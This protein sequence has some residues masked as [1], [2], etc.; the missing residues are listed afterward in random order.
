MSAIVS[1]GIE[2]R[3]T[4]GKSAEFVYIIRGAENEAAVRDAVLAVAPVVYEGLARRYQQIETI[5]FDSTKTDS[6]IHSS[7]VYYGQ[8]EPE[9]NTSA[10][11][12]TG[13]SQHVTQ[14]LSTIGKYPATAPTMQGA[15]GYDGQRV[16]GVDI[17]IPTYEFTETHF[18]SRAQVGTSY[19]FT[20]A[21]LTGGINDA[22]FRGF[23]AGEV[24]FR[25]VTGQLVNVDSGQKWQLNFRFAASPN[26]TNIKIGEITVPS[27]Y[28]W[29]YL[30]VMYNDAVDSGHLVQQPTAC[31]IERLY[32]FVSF[33]DLDIGT[34]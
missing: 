17:V 11:D 2:S 24:Q 32:P 3:Y 33:S 15:I 23:A 19:R 29:D 13:G 18:K 25:G 30:W 1:Q 31:Y 34:S 10:F 21:Q 8:V 14:S 6:N 4:P 22:P 16:N 28:G 26:R 27:K 5:H 12:T 20:L 7:M 9:D